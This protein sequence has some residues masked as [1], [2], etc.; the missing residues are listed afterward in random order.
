M[1]GEFYGAFCGRLVHACLFACVFLSSHLKT[2][3]PVGGVEN[4][5]LV[6]VFSDENESL[7]IGIA[8]GFQFLESGQA[9]HDSGHHPVHGAV[10]GVRVDALQNKCRRVGGRGHHFDTTRCAG[11][12]DCRRAG[13]DVAEAWLRAPPLGSSARGRS[14]SR[15]DLPRRRR[16]TLASVPCRRLETVAVTV[17]I[18]GWAGTSAL[19]HLCHN[20]TSEAINIDGARYLRGY[21]TRFVQRSVPVQC[22]GLVIRGRRRLGMRWS[23]GLFGN[24]NC[25][26]TGMWSYIRMCVHAVF[27]V[28]VSAVPTTGA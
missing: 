19:F 15:T 26:L 6:V 5:A 8:A 11:A 13:G 22:I 12:D 21:V 28:H 2:Q 7:S 23:G 3:R 10:R 17:T 24:R 25:C 4:G 18:R 9:A 20:G 1:T 14:V 27:V 16:G